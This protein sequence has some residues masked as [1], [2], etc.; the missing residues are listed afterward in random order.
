MA[1]R[2]QIIVK[3]QIGHQ[4]SAVENPKTGKPKSRA[5]TVVGAFL[6]IAPNNAKAANI[7][8]IVANKPPA[9]LPIPRASPNFSP[10][11]AKLTL[12]N[13]SSSFFFAFYTAFI[14]HPFGNLIFCLKKGERKSLYRNADYSSP[15]ASTNRPTTVAIKRAATQTNGIRPINAVA[16]SAPVKVQL[17]AASVCMF[18]TCSTTVGVSAKPATRIMIRLIIPIIFAAGFNHFTSAQLLI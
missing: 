9:K 8:I 1:T 18:C 13:L 15:L 10:K 7:T 16:P 17:A 12:I 14:T 4:P 3:T 5:S 6:F 2:R 11:S